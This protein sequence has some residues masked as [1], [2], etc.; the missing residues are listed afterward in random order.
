MTYTIDIRAFADS[1]SD[2]SLEQLCQENPE[3][4]F[5]TDARGKLIVMSPT[6]SENGKKNAGLV[7]QIWYWNNQCKLGEVFDSSTGF[8]L[9][10]GATRSPDVSW[11]AIERW[12]SLSKEQKRGF[13]PIDPDFVIEL[14]SAT[15]NLEDLQQKMSEYISCGVKLGWLINSDAKFVEIYR[16]DRDKQVISN[17]SSLSGEDILPGLSVD[18]SDIFEFC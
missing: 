4:R 15:D 3:L 17:P 8:K 7:A 9:S 12:N 18:L 10:N 11:I 1:I 2:R 6:G 14:M 13:A 5:E 16:L